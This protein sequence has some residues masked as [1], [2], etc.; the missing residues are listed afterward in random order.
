MAK[1][2]FEQPILNS[3]YGVPTQHHAL[4]GDGQPLGQQPVQGWRFGLISRFR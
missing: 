1:P 3:A 4:D 2:F